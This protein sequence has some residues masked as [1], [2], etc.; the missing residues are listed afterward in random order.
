MQQNLYILTTTAEFNG[1]SSAIYKNR[2]L[3]LELKILV[4]L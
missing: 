4:K 3:H 2:T 1:R